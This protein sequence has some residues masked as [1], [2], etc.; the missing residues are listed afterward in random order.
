MVFHLSVSSSFQSSKQSKG[1]IDL[2][3]GTILAS[4]VF[5]MD[6]DCVMEQSTFYPGRCIQVT[7]RNVK[8]SVDRFLEKSELNICYTLK[9]TA[10]IR[11]SHT[12]WELSVAISTATLF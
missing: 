5:V 4:E 6:M 3:K 7:W 1:S 10:L 12:F 9:N 8:N 11:N 2:L